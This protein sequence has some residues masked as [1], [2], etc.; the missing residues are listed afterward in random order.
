MTTSYIE[1]SNIEIHRGVV[2]F[3]DDVFGWFSPAIQ[4]R[5]SAGAR[6]LHEPLRRD[7]FTR[8]RWGAWD[9]RGT[10]KSLLG[11]DIWGFPQRP[12]SSILMGFSMINHPLLGTPILG[13]PHMVVSIVMVVPPKWMVYKGNSHEKMDDVGVALFVKPPYHHIV[14]DGICMYIYIYSGSKIW[15]LWNF[16]DIQTSEMIAVK[17]GWMVVQIWFRSVYG[18]KTGMILGYYCKGYPL[19]IKHSNGR[20][21]GNISLLNQEFQ[22]YC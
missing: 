17:H 10:G 11:A 2:R 18:D 14:E 19:V 20:C 12:K 1:S 21:P 9:Q 16:E 13:T 7:S 22:D 15:M 4:G 8:L 6:A 3:S 5:P